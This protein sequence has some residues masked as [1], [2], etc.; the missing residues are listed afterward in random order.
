M[1]LVYAIFM[2]VRD[3]AVLG[4][5]YSLNACDMTV[6]IQTLKCYMIYYT[7]AFSDE[8]IEEKGCVFFLSLY[9]SH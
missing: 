3:S 6:V 1:L 2:Y 7:G 9:K 4:Y 8:R 5:Q